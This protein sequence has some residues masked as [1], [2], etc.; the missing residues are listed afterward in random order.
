MTSALTGLWHVRG[1]P[2][3]TLLLLAI[4]VVVVA[5][6]D[7]SIAVDAVFDQPARGLGTLELAGMVLGSVLPAL[8]APSFDDRERLAHGP[9]RVV[10]TAVTLVVLLIP[11]PFLPLWEWAV[12]LDPGAKLPPVGGFAANLVLFSAVG[13]ALLLLGGRT[14]SV[15]GT[16]VLCIGFVVGQQVFP[17]SILTDWWATPE[18]LGASGVTTAGLILLVAVL[19]WARGSVARL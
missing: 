10:Q 6:P 13:M 12:L 15:V 19:A 17:V 11:L 16:P 9:P 3:A 2:A 8:T 14:A 5:A 1:G 4:G 7:I 18:Y